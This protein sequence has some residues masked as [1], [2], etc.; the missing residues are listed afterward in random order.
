M[1]CIEMVHSKKIIIQSLIHPHALKKKDVFE[2]N[3][4]LK[5]IHGETALKIK[6]TGFKTEFLALK[7]HQGFLLFKKKNVNIGLQ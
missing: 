1:T 6:F 4:I 3:Q 5:G 7:Q 2:G